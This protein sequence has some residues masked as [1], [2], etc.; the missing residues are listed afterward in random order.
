MGQTANWAA[1]VESFTR[2]YYMTFNFGIISITLVTYAV[3]AYTCRKQ[4]A[5]FLRPESSRESTVQVQRRGPR[6]R[7]EQHQHVEH[8]LILPSAMSAVLAVSGQILIV[9]DIFPREWQEAAANMTFMLTILFNS[10]PRL[11]F[12]RLL[13]RS[14]ISFITRQTNIIAPKEGVFFTHP[15]GSRSHPLS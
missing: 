1:Y 6:L 9:C 8:R 10:I 13:R 11:L 4:L 3:V 14:M 15:S 12:S 7:H 2:V 5:K